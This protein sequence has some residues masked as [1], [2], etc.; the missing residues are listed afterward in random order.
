MEECPCID[1]ICI[2][3]CR[4]KHFLAVFIGCSIAR[5][6]EPNYAAINKRSRERL[7]E[8]EKALNSTRWEVLNEDKTIESGLTYIQAIFDT[9]TYTPQQ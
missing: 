2:P 4:H 6:Y 3:I 1:C 8:V 7:I 9:L 5:E